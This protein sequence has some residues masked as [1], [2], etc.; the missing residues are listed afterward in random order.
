MIQ[1][2]FRRESRRRRRNKTRMKRTGISTL[3]IAL[4]SDDFPDR[5]CLY[6]RKLRS[7]LVDAGIR[8]AERTFPTT[9]R[10]NLWSTYGLYIWVMSGVVWKNAL[11]II[12]HHF[13]HFRVE[14]LARRRIRYS[15][16]GSSP[17]V[18]LLLS[19]DFYEPYR[20]HTHL[21]SFVSD[22]D[23]GSYYH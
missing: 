15:S 13:P 7:M 20:D 19:A 14:R 16:S 1:P 4:M 2:C 3:K 8:A 21:R 10:R 5:H 6:D 17:R 23:W 11:R 18:P 9:R 12:E 22:L